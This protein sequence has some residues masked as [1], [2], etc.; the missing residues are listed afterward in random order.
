METETPQLPS[1]YELA[2]KLRYKGETVIR[3]TVDGVDFVFVPG[4]EH[5]NLPADEYLFSLWKQ[6]YFEE[7]PQTK[8]KGAKVSEETKISTKPL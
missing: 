1:A 6:G 4:S 3:H 5:D 2:S 8:K 7:L